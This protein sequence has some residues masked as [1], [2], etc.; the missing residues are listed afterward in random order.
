MVIVYLS[1]CIV[2]RQKR[3]GHPKRGTRFECEFPD[4]LP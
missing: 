4:V 1:V 3:S 2:L